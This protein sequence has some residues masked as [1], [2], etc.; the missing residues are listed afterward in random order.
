M[1]RLAFAVLLVEACFAGMAQ[2]QAPA[3][4][5]LHASIREASMHV[6][7]LLPA[8][9][10]AVQAYAQAATPRQSETDWTRV[11]ALPMGTNVTIVVRD[12]RLFRTSICL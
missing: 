7:A 8:S 5:P 4:G 1:I 2:A 11:T 6:A 3:G 12:A 10:I 9:S